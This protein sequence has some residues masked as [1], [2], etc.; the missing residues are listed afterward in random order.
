MD[1]IAGR[2]P[3]SAA[4]NYSLYFSPDGMYGNSFHGRVTGMI[5]E[6]VHRRADFAVADLTVTEARSKLVTF[7][8]PFISTHLAAL[9][10]KVDVPRS[11]KTIEDLVKFNAGKPSSLEE[12][13]DRVA[14]GSFTSGATT[15]KLSQA[16][17]E[18]GGAIYRW[19]QAHPSFMVPSM[20]R[21]LEKV[22]AGRYAFIVESTFAEHLAGQDCNLTVL[23]DSGKLYERHFA[24][25]LPKDSPLVGDFNAAI[26][27]M[28]AD[29]TIEGLKRRYWQNNCK[30]NDEEDGEKKVES[31]SSSSSNSTAV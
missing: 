9:V 11:V 16:T 7:S 6:V 22:K 14:Y 15:F 12:S 17:D 4:F 30:T 5:G 23:A 24:I 1:G 25:A 21:G 29:G 8:T 19:L 13:P 18:V 3:P 31:S 28:K 27:S 26:E 10:R 2:V 20:K